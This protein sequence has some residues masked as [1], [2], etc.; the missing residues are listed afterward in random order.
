[1]KNPQGQHR[2]PVDR[3]PLPKGRKYLTPGQKSLLKAFVDN[4][5]RA[6]VATGVRISAYNPGLAL[7]SRKVFEAPR[8]EQWV[9][10]DKA[11][12]IGYYLLTAAGR[13]AFSRGWYVPRSGD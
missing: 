1:M 8:R 7:V 13:E 3:Q 2:G 12:G 4:A 11:L 10:T 5:G 9:I 6:Q